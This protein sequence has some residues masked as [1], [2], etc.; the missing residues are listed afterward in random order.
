[1]KHLQLQKKKI[2]DIIIKTPENAVGLTT[3]ELAKYSETS[4][5]SVV[6]FAKKIGYSSYGE[7]KI[8]LRKKY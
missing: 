4:P 2:A 6:R 7:M 1:M 3:N 5:A 8:E